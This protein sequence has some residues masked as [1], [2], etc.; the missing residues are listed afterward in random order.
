MDDITRFIELMGKADG[1]SLSSASEHESEPYIE[2]GGRELSEPKC[3]AIVSA[4]RLA[5]FIASEGG[6]EAAQVLAVA[7]LGAWDADPQKRAARA[8][9]AVLQAL[10][11]A[12][13]EGT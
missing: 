4:L 1:I 8:A 9:V 2:W 11:R 5:R 12:A 7:I 10:A 3:A 6:E 13:L